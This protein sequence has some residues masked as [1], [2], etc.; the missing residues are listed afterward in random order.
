MK[1]LIHK[2][3]DY[4]YFIKWY[5]NNEFLYLPYRVNPKLIS[6]I[7][8]WHKIVEENW[9]IRYRDIDL[10]SYKK[11]SNKKSRK[12]LCW[13]N[14]TLIEKYSLPVRPTRYNLYWVIRNL[15]L[16]T[17]YDTDWNHRLQCAN[18][19]NFQKIW[20]KMNS[21]KIIFNSQKELNFLINELIDI[22]KEDHSFFWNKYIYIIERNNSKVSIEKFKRKKDINDAKIEKFLFLS[23]NDMK[24]KYIKV[25][26]LDFIKNNY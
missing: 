14:E 20:V 13:K 6:Y 3:I 8:R 12:Q 18:E 4:Y 17:V 25:S 26:F 7:N 15:K 19:N 23:K 9:N 10:F 16:F 1:T 2:I 24:E 11:S 21:I 5:I 22:F